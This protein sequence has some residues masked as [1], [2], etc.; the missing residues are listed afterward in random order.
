MSVFTISNRFLDLYDPFWICRTLSLKMGTVAIL[1]FLC[2]AF[3][4][5]PF[6]SVPFILT[7]LVGTAA[8]EILPTN[9][10]AKKLGA[11]FAIVIMLAIPSTLF[12]LFSYLKL[13]L[14]L[15]VI[16]FTYF[17]L[18]FM[19]INTKAAA[20]PVMML[21]WGM[22]QLAGGAATDL[23]GVMNNLLYYFEFAMMG[24]LT[25]IFF[26]NFTP[27]IFKSAF[28]RVMEHDVEKLGSQ[29]FKNSDP[30]VLS[31]LS[32]MRSKLSMLPDAYRLLYDSVIQFQS[33]CMNQL[34]LSEEDQ[35]LVKSVL[36]TLIDAVGH[37]T[38]FSDDNNHLTQL[39]TK[40]P[41]LHASLRRLIDGYDQCQ[42]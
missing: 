1:L 20:V 39:E 8:T 19:A 16:S 25:V 2:N 21:V 33:D 32:M 4:L 12:G 28:M 22:M 23:V 41:R 24:A 34:N 7:A 42:A 27:Y 18:R 26:P 9:S 30:K 10:K 38:V 3:L 36:M 5:A 13:G 35:H 31:A 6:S 37:Q 15:L 40:H 11:L 29:K 14:F 17:A